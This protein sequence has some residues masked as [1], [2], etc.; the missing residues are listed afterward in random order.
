MLTLQSVPRP[1][2]PARRVRLLIHQ[3]A[4]CWLAVDDQRRRA[5]APLRQLL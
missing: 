2:G 3:R 4:A 1:R 5:N